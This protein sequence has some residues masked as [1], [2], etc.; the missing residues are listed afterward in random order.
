[1]VVDDVIDKK[2]KLGK[3]PENKEID[4]LTRLKLSEAQ[5]PNI[6][7]KFAPHITFFHK[8]KKSQKS[9]FRSKLSRK[10]LWENI[11]GTPVVNATMN[12]KKLD[13]T[14]VLKCRS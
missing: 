14:K 12:Y 6:I 3:T 5:I 13:N 4:S 11:L 1:M 9:V 8:I 7:V 10:F 2:T